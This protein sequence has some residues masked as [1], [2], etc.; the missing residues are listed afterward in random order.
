M[1]LDVSTQGSVTVGPSGLERGIPQSARVFVTGKPPY[2]LELAL[3]YDDSEA[4]LVLDQ[5]KILRQTEGIPV[6]TA[7][8]QQVRIP[9]LIATSLR[10]QVLDHRGWQ[11]LIEDHPD[12]DQVA[13][14]ALVYSL[15]HALADPRPTQTVAT[16]RGLKP[17]SGIKRVMRAR[18]L[19]F[20]GAAQRGRSAI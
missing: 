15:A 9:D 19:G 18:E 20:L 4:R 13:V 7:E 17:G 5:I 2:D 3:E 6:R 12:H 14:D 1:H 10:G 11:G 8:L 16:A